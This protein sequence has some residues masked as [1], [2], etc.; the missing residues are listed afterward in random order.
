MA[1][2]TKGTKKATAN[3]TVKAA[4]PATVTN[5]MVHK[6]ASGKWVYPQGQATVTLLAQPKGM[7]SNQLVHYAALQAAFGSSTTM[8]LP[9]LIA[10][11]AGGGK[12][13]RT[14][15]RAGRAQCYS[16]VVK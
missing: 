8:A 1:K 11:L 2:V 10:A 16:F 4:K 3:K 12:G 13:R 5:L 6:A 14:L 7:G 9:A 15:R